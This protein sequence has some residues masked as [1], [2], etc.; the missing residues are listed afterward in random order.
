MRIS[1]W[2]S[3]VCSSDL[4]YIARG[5]RLMTASFASGPVRVTSTPNCRNLPR[6]SQPGRLNFALHAAYGGRGAAPKSHLES[7][8]QPG[9]P[10][11]SRSEESRVGK[12][13]V[14]TCS[15]RWS[16][17][18]YKKKNKQYTNSHK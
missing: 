12:E 2:S 10:L 17:Y 18:H 6:G 13:C 1:D 15:T 3:D 8:A 14:S 11:G 7:T 4:V 9:R 16:P 5:C